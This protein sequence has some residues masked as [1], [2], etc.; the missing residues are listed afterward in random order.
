MKKLL[1]IDRDGT[2]IHEPV[3]EQQV[4]SLEKLS[5]IP[6]VITSLN[7]IV[8]NTDYELIMVTNQDG[9]GTSSFPEEHFW[10][11]HNKMLEILKNEGIIFKDVLIDPS[12]EHENS[13]GRKPRTGLM[14]SYLEGDYDL[15]NSFV[16]G[17]RYTDMEF[18]KNLGAKGILFGD[19]K[20]DEAVMNTND[21]EEIV[22]YLIL[23]DRKAGISRKT[24]ET[25]IQ[26]EINLDGSGIADISTGIGFFDHM[27][28]QIARHG[29]CDLSIKVKGDLEVDEHH[30]IEDTGLALGEVFTQ[31]LGDKRGIQRYGFLLPMDDSLAQVAIDFG[32]RPWLEWDVT[33][34]REKLGEMPTEMFKHFFKSF[35]DT[36][37]CN[38]NIKAEG[39]NNH[40]KVESIFKALAKS[41]KMAKERSIESL[42]RIPSTKG[43]L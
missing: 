41:I 33:F 17:D 32:G 36:A 6:K 30:T 5:F 25:D 24:R 28:E 2:I 37:K 34:R 27:L 10:P 19:K 16:I 35:S 39:E 23:P 11:A 29:V 38:L 1:I 13:P 42:N 21:W 26:A 22:K 9:L 12:F 18:A 4:D 7:T 40:H 20:S 43:I 31:A 3:E 15:A 8:N 14:K